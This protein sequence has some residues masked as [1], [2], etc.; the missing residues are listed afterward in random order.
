MRTTPAVAEYTPSFQILP[1]SPYRHVNTVILPYH[2]FHRFPFPESK[3]KF[4]QVRILSGYGFLYFLFPYSGECASVSERPV[5]F[6]YGDSFSLFLLFFHL[7]HNGYIAWREQPVAATISVELPLFSF[8]RTII[9]RLSS[10]AVL[11]QFSAILLFHSPKVLLF[12]QY[13]NM[14][15]AGSLMKNLKLLI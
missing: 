9:R 8:M 6:F 15:I 12:S 5:A 13:V 11:L 2:Q 14:Y 4:Q 3:V 7:F 1:D 10:N